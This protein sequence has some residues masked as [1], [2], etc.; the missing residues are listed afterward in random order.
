MSVFGV[1]EFL[2]VFKSVA[3]CTRDA[4]VQMFTFLWHIHGGVTKATG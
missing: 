4:A 1:Q 2:T 3:L